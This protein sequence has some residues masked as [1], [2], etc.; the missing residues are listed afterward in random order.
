[1][2]VL[3]GFAVTSL[4]IAGHTVVEGEEEDGAV[5]AKVCGT[6]DPF[7]DEDR[8]EFIDFHNNL[9]KKIARG[10]AP[11]FT[12]KLPS[13]KNMY[14]L[15]YDC[16]MEKELQTKLKSCDIPDFTYTNGYGQNIIKFSKKKFESISEIKTRVLIALELWSNPIVYYGIK[17]GDEVLMYDDARLNTFANVTRKKQK[18]PGGGNNTQ[19]KGNDEMD[20]LARDAILNAHNE[21]PC[22]RPGSEWEKLRQIADIKIHAKNV[23]FFEIYDCHTESEAIKYASTCSFVKSSESRREGYG[24]NVFVYPVPNADPVLAFKAAAASWWAQITADSIGRDVKFTESLKAKAVQTEFAQMAW[25]KSVKLGCAIQT[26]SLSSF[27][28]CRYS[29][30]GNI[31]NENIYEIGAICSGCS[32]AC[33]YTEGLCK[34]YGFMKELSLSY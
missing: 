20:D 16:N 28:V 25:G 22:K 33:N 21:P 7:K 14:A 30:A 31:V 12:G 10:D 5:A 19:C 1:M 4:L 11:N 26:C 13:A 15:N 32:S 6:T 8:T 24:E 17:N 34:P 3:F 2:V 9:R 27:I 23:F 18:L 29:P